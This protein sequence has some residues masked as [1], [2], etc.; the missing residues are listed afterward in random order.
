MNSQAPVTDTAVGS[1]LPDPTTVVTELRELTAV[2][3][4]FSSTSRSR[5]SVSRVRV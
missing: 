1:R 4:R 3:Y 5:S 2:L